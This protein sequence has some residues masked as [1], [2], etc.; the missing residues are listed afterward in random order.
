MSPVREESPQM[1]SKTPTV[2]RTRM[3]ERRQ[4]AI[5]NEFADQGEDAW[6]WWHWWHWGGNWWL[7]E[8]QWS[9]SL[10]RQA[11]PIDGADARL[12][13]RT[14]DPVIHHAGLSRTRRVGLDSPTPKS[15][16]EFNGIRHL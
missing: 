10:A 11:K 3:R 1:N 15:H 6:H 7:R 14:T 13:I 8:A 4:F 5:E 12:P 9:N 2:L 16:A